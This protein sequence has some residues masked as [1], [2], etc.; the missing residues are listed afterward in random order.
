M[1]FYGT[2]TAKGHYRQDMVEKSLGV[3]ILRSYQGRDVI[4][5]RLGMLR[6]SVNEIEKLRAI[7]ETRK[8]PTALLL[9]L[10]L[11]LATRQGSIL[12]LSFFSYLA[13]PKSV[14][15]QLP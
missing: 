3:G 15:D 7:I 2:S 13:G 12:F 8:T 10:Q 4:V 14:S 5:R 6:P 11:A 9:Q 1:L